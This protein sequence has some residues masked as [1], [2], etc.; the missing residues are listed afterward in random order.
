MLSDPR[1]L[2]ALILITLLPA[3]ALAPPTTGPFPAEAVAKVAPWVLEHTANGAQADFLVVL[4]DQADVSAAARLPEK[5]ERGRYVRAA[6]WQRA[7][8]RPAPTARLVGPTRH[9]LSLVLHCQPR[10]PDR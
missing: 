9:P 8:I 1:H 2:L 7:Q 5:I 3:S 6:L 10:C 4:N